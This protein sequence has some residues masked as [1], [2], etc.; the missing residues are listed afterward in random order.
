VEGEGEWSQHLHVLSPNRT[1]LK[2]P[3]TPSL[4]A[5]TTRRCSGGRQVGGANKSEMGMVIEKEVL[6]LP[7]SEVIVLFMSYGGGGTGSIQNVCRV[8]IFTEA[9][10]LFGWKLVRHLL[11]Y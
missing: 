11:I 9:F 1:H 10:V 7:H 3:G 2:L 5:D 4:T 6:V 8:S